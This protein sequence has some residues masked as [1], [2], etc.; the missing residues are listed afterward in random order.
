MIVA[1][2]L[3]F[4]GLEA[5]PKATP[6]A[7]VS[8][9]EL[10]VEKLK[11]EIERSKLE[12]QKLQLELEKDR[13]TG[14]QTRKDENVSQKESKTEK[15]QRKARVVEEMAAK[16]AELAKQTEAETDRMVFDFT[17]GEVWFK[18]IRHSMNDLA[19]LF[20]HEGVKVKRNLLKRKSNGTGRYEYAYRNL[21]SQR[22]EQQEK[23]VFVWTT[24][25]PEGGYSFVTPEGYSSESPYGE[26]R[27]RA[28][29]DYFTYDK[30]K[31]KGK[32][33]ILRFKN[34]G[35]F[36]KFPEKLN[37]WVDEKD[38]LAKIEWGILDEN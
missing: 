35:G 26:I 18:G 37:F 25:G 9:R 8:D 31:K 5:A 13:M 12:N 20:D 22:Y 16:S 10:E 19:E 3:S 17:N 23:G 34:K 38:R 36:F 14:N 32:F 24:P 4:T 21:A 15:K 2:C 11:L 1:S 29:N 30:Q 27:N 33:R 6:T 28:E 7:S